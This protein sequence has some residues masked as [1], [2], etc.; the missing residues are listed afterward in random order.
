MIIS[1]EAAPKLIGLTKVLLVVSSN[2]MSKE[3]VIPG[4]TDKETRSSVCSL[5]ASL[6]TTV[7]TTF[8]IKPVI[9]VSVGLKL[10]TW[11]LPKSSKN[12]R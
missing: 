8:S 11:P 10:W 5:C 6:Q 4:V 9:S 3:V 7:P 12:N 1:T 2:W